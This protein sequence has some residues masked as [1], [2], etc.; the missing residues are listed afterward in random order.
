MYKDKYKSK[1]SFSGM[2]NS[3]LSWIHRLNMDSLFT[4]KKIACWNMLWLTLPCRGKRSNLVA[5]QQT[6]A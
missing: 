1:V 6:V 3:R 5:G 2:R 4:E